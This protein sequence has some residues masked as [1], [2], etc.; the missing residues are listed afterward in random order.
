MRAENRS[1]LL[2]AS[3]LFEHRDHALRH[4]TQIAQCTIGLLLQQIRFPV[5][6]K[7]IEL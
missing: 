3:K 6:T 4:R 2:T 5:R 1:N 7:F